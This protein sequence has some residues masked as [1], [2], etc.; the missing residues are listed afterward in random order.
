MKQCCVRNQNRGGN[1]EEKG[2]KRKTTVLEKRLHACMLR[3][4]LYCNVLMWSLFFSIWTW[5]GPR[6]VLLNIF[7]VLVFFLFLYVF[8]PSSSLLLLSPSKEAVDVPI[9]EAADSQLH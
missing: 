3:V 8:P 2:S 1:V 5:L 7:H 6:H 4:A 9:Y